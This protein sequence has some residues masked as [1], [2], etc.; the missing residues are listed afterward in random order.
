MLKSR[1]EIEVSIVL[2]AMDLKEIRKEIFEELDSNY[3]AY[4]KCVFNELKNMYVKNKDFTK[5]DSCNWQVLLEKFRQI[6]LLNFFQLFL[7][8]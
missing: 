5:K 2:A 7:L 1:N 8:K 6:I 4:E 3:F